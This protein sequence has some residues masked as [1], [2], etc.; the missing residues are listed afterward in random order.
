MDIEYLLIL[1]GLREAA[2]PLA[3]QFFLMVSSLLAGGVMV[4][5]PLLIYWCIDKRAGF[6]VFLGYGC[7]TAL[8]NLV[9]CIACVPR[10]WVRDP[11]IIPSEAAV[12]HAT[13]YSFP[14]GHTQGAMSVYGGAGWELREK[15]WR[16]PFFGGL[17]VALIGFSRNFLGVHTPQDVLAGILEG[18][19]VIWLAGALLTWLEASDE[20][21]SKVIAFGAAILTVIYLAFVTLKRYPVSSEAGTAAPMDM[22][23]DA[24]EAAG[25]F[26][27]VIVGWRLERRYVGFSVE[28]SALEK[29]IRFVVGG[30]IAVA[31]R[32]P[33]A[34]FLGT[35]IGELG[36]DFLKSFLPVL[37]GIA[38]WP[39]AFPFIGRLFDRGGRS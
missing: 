18:A 11:R 28:G 15:G 39:A 26:L 7:A 23:L 36:G 38:V 24:Y 22:L 35:F 21:Q 19:L 9:K 14:S 12:E 30:A 3:E 34:G 10:P 25:L 2:G 1:Q 27:A 32:Y 37:F 33:V 6:A 13:G 31:L 29:I 16:A 17:L 8:T 20:G 5:I 4:A